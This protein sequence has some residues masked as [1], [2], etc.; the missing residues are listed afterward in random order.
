MKKRH[1]VLAILTIG[2]FS[3]CQMEFMKFRKS[4]EKQG[5]MFAKKGLQS[6][7]FQ[8][9]VI[10]GQEMHYTKMAMIACPWCCCCMGRLARRAP[11]WAT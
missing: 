7:D 4:D 2:L 10:D 1:T 11:A 5:A 8:R 6:A 3:T 9:Y